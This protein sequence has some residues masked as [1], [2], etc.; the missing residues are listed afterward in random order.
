ML[1]KDA[2]V[3]PPI[4]PQ[5]RDQDVR[6][7]LLP[8]AG[9]LVRVKGHVYERGGSRSISVEQIEEVKE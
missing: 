3:Y 1:T 2:Q 9:K 5:M 8:Y 7:K 6:A 4:S